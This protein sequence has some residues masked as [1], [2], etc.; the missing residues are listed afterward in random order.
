[1]E[2]EQLSLSGTCVCWG[3]GKSLIVLVKGTWVEFE[4]W[5]FTS[6]TVL[7]QK[8]GVLEWH[9]RY[10]KLLAIEYYWNNKSEDGQADRSCKTLQAFLNILEL[11]LGVMINWRF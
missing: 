9:D 2:K 6:Q 7:K 3:V 1:M 4:E 10:R 8:H 11:N 5:I